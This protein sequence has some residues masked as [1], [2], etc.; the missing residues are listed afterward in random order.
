MK[1]ARSVYII[2]IIIFYFLPGPPVSPGCNSSLLP[3]EV[4]GKLLF[5]LEFEVPP[6]ELP[7]VPPVGPFVEL[8]EVPPV[9]PFVELPEVP[10]FGELVDPPVLAFVIFPPVGPLEELVDPPEAPVVPGAVL[11][12]PGVFEL[13]WPVLFIV[14]FP[15]GEPLA[16]L[17][18]VFAFCSGAALETPL[19]LFVSLR[20]TPSLSKV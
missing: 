10:P 15:A 19:M 13:V 3:V 18:P 20:H 4:P 12:P 7:E 9:G 2:D 5:E 6:V 11:V 8:P 17:L 1:Y 14:V 16:L